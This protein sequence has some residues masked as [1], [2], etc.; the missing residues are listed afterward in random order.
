M[1]ALGVAAERGA[2]TRRPPW[3]VVALALTFILA[4][5]LAVGATLA[6]RASTGAGTSV[7]P[8]T[9]AARSHASPAK[10]TAPMT[11]YRDLVANLK[12]AERRHD[13]AAQARFG[14]QLK[15]ILTAQ[16]IGLIRHE[17]ARLESYL[18]TAKA[19]REYHAASMINQRIS[20]LCGPKTVRAQLDFCN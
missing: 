5:A 18:A 12:A 17:H 9:P 10:S 8:I 2:V 16:T 11:A 19:N 1:S 20:V 13:L 14:S 6:G 7:S 3:A 4:I 15:A